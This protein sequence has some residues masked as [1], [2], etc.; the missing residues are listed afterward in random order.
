MYLVSL[1]IL[2]MILVICGLFLWDFVSVCLW[3]FGLRVVF[4]V[5]VFLVHSHF[6]CGSGYFWS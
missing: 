4:R 5:F 1:R 3:C 6:G 2:Y